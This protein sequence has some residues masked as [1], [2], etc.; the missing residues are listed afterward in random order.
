MTVKVYDSHHGFNLKLGTKDLEQ[1]VNFT[2]DA[3]PEICFEF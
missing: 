2:H 1:N 3:L